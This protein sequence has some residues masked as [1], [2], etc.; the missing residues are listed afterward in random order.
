[1]IMQNFFNVTE[2]GVKPDRPDIIQTEVIQKVIDIAAAKGGTVFFP[3]GNYKSGSLFFKKGT[4]LVLE[5]NAFLQGSSD[6]S[7]FAVLPTRLEGENVI[8]FAALINA[9]KADD[10]SISGEGTLD[11]NGLPY[12]RHFWLRRKFNPQCTNMDEMR[13]RIIYIS[14]SKNVVI[15]GVTIQNS[16]F[17]TTHF[18][19]CSNLTL[20]NLT[21][22][23]P[24]KPVL[25]P[26]SDAID[27]DVCNDV[28]I[29]GC[30]ISVNDDAIA[31]KGG[32][33]PEADK[34]AENGKNTRII[35]ENCTFGFCHCILTCGSET[36]HNDD[37]IVR[38]CISDGAACLF[39][40]KMRPDTNQLNEN[41]LIENI[42]GYCKKIFSSYSFTQFRRS[43]DLH[44]SYGRN[45]TLQN[46]DLKCDKLITAEKS[47]EY[48]LKDIH[49]YNCSF[50]CPEELKI[51]FNDGKD[52]ILENVKI[53]HE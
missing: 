40:L 38:N 27:L 21:I 46:I 14:N 37:I 31:L 33:G 3:Q 52:F 13:P 16:P 53:T 39:S 42:T 4:A 28:L 50:I 12:W 11:G 29:S 1:M 43:P 10:F 25:A 7:D 9:D 47:I 35:I 36:I 49:L 48:E 17:W 34:L 45:I 18:Y 20:Q 19:R 22:Y 15:S 44:M 5:K 30:N 2:Y 8:Y 51:D 26:S 24:T 32:K 6:I 23:A 41:I